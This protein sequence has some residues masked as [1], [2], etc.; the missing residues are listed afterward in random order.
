MG[1]SGSG[2]NSPCS[3][4]EAWMCRWYINDGGTQRT[5]LKSKKDLNSW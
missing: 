3:E 2:S 4:G 5:S 1:A